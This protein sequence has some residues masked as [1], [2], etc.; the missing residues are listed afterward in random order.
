[1]PPAI[2]NGPR[3]GGQLSAVMVSSVPRSASRVFAEA[4]RSG[5]NGTENWRV[6]GDDG[7][8]KETLPPPRIKGGQTEEDNDTAGSVSGCCLLTGSMQ[9]DM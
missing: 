2:W 1:M 4:G 3:S 7:L 5:R 6:V 8:P 9:A